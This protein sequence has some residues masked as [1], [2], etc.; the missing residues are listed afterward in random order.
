MA[1]SK[2]ILPDQAVTALQSAAEALV[3]AGTVT[4]A[5]VGADYI[6][7]WPIESEEKAREIAAAFH[8]ALYGLQQ[9]HIVVPS[10]HG[11]A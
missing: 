7:M 2:P 1:S 9:L 10:Q 6:S 11:R 5:S 4:N 3:R 8:A